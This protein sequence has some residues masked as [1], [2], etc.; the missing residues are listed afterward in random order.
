M[1]LWTTGII[2]GLFL[3]RCLAL[4]ALRPS[5]IEH[6][7]TTSLEPDVPYIP[8]DSYP[9]DHPYFTFTD[10]MEQVGT[11]EQ[12][13]TDKN[14]EFD[15]FDWAYPREIEAK[16]IEITQLEENAFNPE[17]Q[18][19]QYPFNKTESTDSPTAGLIHQRG[20]Q[21]KIVASR[22]RDEIQLLDDYYEDMHHLFEQYEKTVLNHQILIPYNTKPFDYSCT[23]NLG[24]I[25]PFMNQCFAQVFCAIETT[26]HELLTRSLRVL[27]H[28]RETVST[29]HTIL[30]SM[31]LCAIDGTG[32][33][34]I[35]DQLEHGDLSPK[36]CDIF[37]QF[38]HKEK[39]GPES[40]VKSIK[41]E[42]FMAS[43]MIKNAFKYEDSLSLEHE[44]F[45]YHL[46]DVDDTIRN[47]AQL[48]K[49]YVDA[50][51]SPY[52]R[53]THTQSIRQTPKL[54]DNIAL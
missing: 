40:I 28:I 20:S 51:M 1:A 30:S 46:S 15:I 39:H 21:L 47:Y 43:H 18:V 42:F 49:Q 3:T 13:Y 44:P 4:L 36:E 23:P 54:R 11:I 45:L 34:T 29:D 14:Y 37:I 53:K 19:T 8:I 22:Y 26:D 12:K 16:R 9:S 24:Y 33:Q 38:L 2:A 7:S 31:I 6:T 10:L 17:F 27:E 32:H 5:W 25:R 41:F 48:Q 50:M 52:P 35:V